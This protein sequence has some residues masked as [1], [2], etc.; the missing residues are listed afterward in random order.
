MLEANLDNDFWYPFI[1]IFKQIRMLLTRHIIIPYQQYK[2]SFWYD[3]E[4][5]VIVYA[6]QEQNHVVKRGTSSTTIYNSYFFNFN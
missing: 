1:T 3:W 2:H 6:A 4:D 5:R